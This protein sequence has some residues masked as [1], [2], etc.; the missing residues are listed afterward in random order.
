[1]ELRY[2]QAEAIDSA[3]RFLRERS[4]ENPCIVLP[5][6][7]GKTPV[8]ASICNDAV[9]R[10]DSRVLV[11]SHVKEL[12]EQSAETLR[13]W[14]PGLDVGVYSAGVGSRDK[15]NKV[16]VAGVQSV[17]KR[18]F[19]LCGSD[20]FSLVLVDEAH[21]I[22][23]DG[24][25]M[26]Q[27]LLRDIRTANPKARVIGLTAT[28]YRTKGGYVCG[29]DHFL[30]DICYEVSVRELIAG[31]YLARLTS[32]QSSGD[33]DLSGVSVR[34]GE[35]ASGEMEAAFDEIVGEAVSEIVELSKDRRSVLVFCA[36]VDHAKHVYEELWGRGFGANIITGE[37]S[38]S[39]REGSIAA[40]RRRE[41]KYLLNV[42]VLTEGFDATNVDMVVLLRATLSPGLYYQM[43]GRGLRLHPGKDD[44][45]VL[46]F[47][48]NVLRHGCIDAMKIEK[49]AGGSETGEAPCKTCPECK[50][51]VPIQVTNCTAC[52]FAFPEPEQKPRHEPRA[53]SAAIL[54]SDI[55]PTE[56]QVTEVLYGVHVKRD[57]PEDAPRTMRVS[58]MDG[59]EVVGEEWV[60]IEHQGFALQKAMAWWQARSANSIP[61]DSAEAVELCE[62][63]G[64]AETTA[65]QVLKQPGERFARIV[66][67][68]LGE[69]PPPVDMEWLRSRPAIQW[70]E[71]EEAPF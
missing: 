42:N 19:E 39:D 51:V 67:Y 59:L 14:H 47:G 32:K 33:A 60:C 57:A 44:C 41:I 62:L 9:T 34:Q 31:G 52:G 37:T 56:Y 22:P 16:V 43:V 15:H 21:R 48:G 70:G 61:R 24:D 2:Y 23:T 11:L 17:A 5:T 36:G 49:K 28:P 71:D 25:G 69:I 58:Y 8:L 29:P 68:K 1:M 53:S 35:Y 40:F 27:Q 66:G 45:M 65:I 3:Y 64:I 20:P 26:Y 63:G 7:A 50:E 12:V 38:K 30:N 6:G 55:K 10:W 54:S 4:G 18:G 13:K 46:D